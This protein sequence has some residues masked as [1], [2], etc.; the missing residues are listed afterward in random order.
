M[1][2]TS[3]A[4]VRERALRIDESFIVQ[5]PAGSGKTGLLTQRLLCLLATVDQPEE[6]LAI[7][8]TRKAAAEMRARLLHALAAASS[9]TPAAGAH[10]QRLRSLAQQVCRRSDECGWQLQENP[11]RLKIMTFDALNVRLAGT[12]PLTAGGAVG[13]QPVDDA[14]PLYRQAAREVLALAADDDPDGT[15]VRLLLGHLDSDGGRF[16]EQLAAEL[17]RR[18]QWLRHVVAGGSGEAQRAHLEQALQRIVGQRLGH[19]VA[20][21]PTECVNVLPALITQ[22]AT[23][24]TNAAVQASFAPFPQVVAGTLTSMPA[25]QTDAVGIWR[26]AACLLLTG[27]GRKR[28]LRRSFDKR[29]GFPTEAKEL[30]TCAIALLRSLAEQQH[31]EAALVEISMLPDPSLPD[32]QWALLEALARVLKLATA[33]LQLVAGERGETDFIELALAAQRALGDSEAPTDFALAMDYRLRHL[34]VDEFQDTSHSQ[35][36]LLRRLVTGWEAGDG[37]TLF[38]VGDPMQSIY[39]FREA[40]V[41]LFLRA[42]Q[43]G[44]GGVHLTPLYLSANFRSAPTLVDWVNTLFSRMMPAEEDL[45][46][47]AAPYT[48]AGAAVA[49]DSGAAVEMQILPD[50]QAEAV[51]VVTWLRPLLAAKNPGSIAVLV[52]SRSHMRYILPLLREEGLPVEAVAFEPLAESPAVQELIALARAFTHADDRLAWLGLLRSPCCGLSLAEIHALVH[53][54]PRASVSELL[55]D[56][57]RLSRLAPEARHRAEAFAEVLEHWLDRRGELR[58]ATLVEGCW[59]ALGGPATLNDVR[60]LRDCYAL[61]QRLAELQAGSDL[62]D[63]AELLAQLQRRYREHPPAGEQRIQVMTIHHAK[64]LEF[65][66]VVVCGLGNTPRGDTRPLLTW[67][68]I[69]RADGGAD[70]LL[71]PRPARSGAGRELFEWLYAAEQRRADLE[72]D[73]VLYVAVTR[74][75]RQLL[76]C[77][78]SRA[79]RHGEYTARGN[80]PLARLQTALSERAAAFP[81]TDPVAAEPPSTRWVEASLRQLPARWRPPAAPAASRLTLAEKIAEPAGVDDL[82]FDWASPQAA[83]I[84]RV[85]HEWL[86]VLG[87]EGLQAWPK[88]RLLA[89]QGTWARRL[90]ELGLGVGQ[91]AAGVARIRESL[92]GVLADDTGRWLLQPHLQARCEW[93]LDALLDGTLTR[94][95]IDRSF[96]DEQGRRWIVDYKTGRHEGGDLEGF[97]ASEEARYQPQL[98]RYARVVQLLEPDRAQVVALYFPLLRALRTLPAGRDAALTRGPAIAGDL[99]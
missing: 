8:F 21:L 93:A 63:P 32:E 86:Q 67:R 83:C 87:E 90:R 16:I 99:L 44:L 96:I 97:F 3:D 69:A 45:A 59:L 15:A 22:A 52:R 61:L 88:A 36:E 80:A 76:L 48:P 92:L 51:A 54:A 82:P 94:I 27:T 53:D 35:F 17:G 43:R 79:N 1:M 23:A 7:T 29:S 58:L 55:H 30:K 41:G 34:L 81:A 68:E 77:G 49:D 75:K 31:A 39:R 6:I 5:A 85:V 12:L 64:G 84:G 62:A 13:L 89:Q 40:D 14:G 24:A 74:A 66:H 11:S 25:G 47:G 4:A 71:A 19:A 33:A 9:D 56:P 73:R 37:R 65:D 78:L 26:A 18:D 2:S 91:A 28:C 70:L 38:C 57:V 10:E 50:A 95:V 98:A 60:D 42:R 20:Q 72:T 46:T